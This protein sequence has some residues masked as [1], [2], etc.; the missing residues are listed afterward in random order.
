M[1]KLT[2]KDLDVKGKKVIV[3]VDFNVP[4]IKGKVV[5]TTKIE[6]ALPTLNYL[7]DNGA[8]LIIVS[9]F[10]RPRGQVKEDLRL[11]PIAQVLSDLLGRAVFKAETFEGEEAK[12]AASTLKPGEILLLENIR[13]HPGEE[14]NDPH[15]AKELASMADIFVNDAF[16]T[17]HRAHASTVGIT[18]HLPVVAG[19]LMEKELDYL[20]EV[21]TNPRRPLVAL[22]GGAKVADKMELLNNLLNI[23]DILL[24]GGGMANTFLKAKGYA[25]GASLLE[26]DKVPLAK[27]LMKTAAKKNIPLVL[28]KDLVAAK[29]LKE[30]QETVTVPAKELPEGYLALD[31]GPQTVKEFGHYIK[32]AGTIV[33]NGPLGAFEVEPFGNGTTATA[34][35]IAESQAI[36]IIGGGDVVA[37]IQEAGLA[38]KMTHISTG[39]GATL[40]YLEGKDL[41]G[42]KALES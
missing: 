25:M 20:Q 34:K 2:V 23:V 12:N 40:E 36:S 32:E 16:A 21:L 35:K 18:E 30:N 13:F 26:E 39:G 4:L 7:L 33:W 27:E 8:A 11:N 10:G 38:D 22:I 3:R 28:P 1:D 14:K 9:H 42:V 31:I 24:I 6:A 5:D 37:A 29:E 17:S 19:F 15:F 41:P